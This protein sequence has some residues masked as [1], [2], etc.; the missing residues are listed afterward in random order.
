MLGC[1]GRTDTT[2]VG[3]GFSLV[4]ELG[5]GMV[6]LFVLGFVQVSSFWGSLWSDY[7]LLFSLSPF[8]F[9]LLWVGVS[10][11]IFEVVG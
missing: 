3:L 10:C 9:L 11:E 2:I 6:F 8:V 5:M 1:R 4:G 7:H